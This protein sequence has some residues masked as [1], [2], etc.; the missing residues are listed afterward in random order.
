[1]KPV[2]LEEFKEVGPE[3]F[4]RYFYVADELGEGARAEDI[5]IVMKTLTEQVF[6]RRSEKKETTIGF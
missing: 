2:T 1:M 5:L 6:A 4:E 3:F